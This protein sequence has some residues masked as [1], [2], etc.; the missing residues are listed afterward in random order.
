VQNRRS[1]YVTAPSEATVRGLPSGRLLP[2]NAQLLDAYFGHAGVLAAWRQSGHAVGAD[3]VA[4]FRAE[5]RPLGS[6]L[7]GRWS[8]KARRR[9][10]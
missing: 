9:R 4:A 8:G 5:Q 7:G 10:A 6:V 1:A 2:G 3:L